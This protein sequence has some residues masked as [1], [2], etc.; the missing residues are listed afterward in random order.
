MRRFRALP[1]AAA[2]AAATFAVP[3]AA[4]PAEAAASTIRFSYVRYDA[5]GKDTRKNVNGEFLVVKNYGKK[6]V[7]LSGWT[8]G[9]RAALKNSP[10]TLYFYRKN[11]IVLP[12]RQFVVRMGRGKN[13]K[14]TLYQQ[15]AKHTWPNVKGG[16]HLFTPA[17]KLADSCTWNSRRGYKKC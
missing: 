12:G 2:A 15:F 4:V 6:K 3:L 1:L 9:Y 7:N 14:T 17:D 13:T 16:A 11:V 5:K 8:I 10:L